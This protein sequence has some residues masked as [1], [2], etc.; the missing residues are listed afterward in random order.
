MVGV[1]EAGPD[2]EDEE[3]LAVQEEEIPRRKKL[4]VVGDSIMIVRFTQEGLTAM[5]G[6]NWDVHVVC[7][8]GKM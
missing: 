7:Y 2:V 1:E 3:D 5:L 6:D 4:V 8:R